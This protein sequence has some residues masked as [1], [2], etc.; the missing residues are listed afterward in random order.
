MYKD[1][2]ILN[3]RIYLYFFKH[4]S[5]RLHQDLHNI[6]FVY[7]Y[8][9][10]CDPTI[11]YNQLQRE[12]LFFFLDMQLYFCRFFKTYTNPFIYL[13]NILYFFMVVVYL[14]PVQKLFAHH[15][16]LINASPSFNQIYD[17]FFEVFFLLP[18][19]YLR[20]YKIYLF[21]MLYYIN[22][23]YNTIIY[24]YFA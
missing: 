4:A 5:I 6:H 18:Y 14:T 21:Y 10:L 8:M 20:T 11:P 13:Y 9:I 24:F 3:Y 7:P 15:S 22:I 2:A 16:C 12:V 1:Y 19:W 17:I 23:C